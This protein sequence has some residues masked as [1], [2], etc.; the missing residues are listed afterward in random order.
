MLTVSKFDD[1]V[2]NPSKIKRLIKLSVKTKD[3]LLKELLER[4][5][6]K[7]RKNELRMY[8]ANKGRMPED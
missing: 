1:L 8:V 7:V 6:T 3:N 2:D 4:F 5:G